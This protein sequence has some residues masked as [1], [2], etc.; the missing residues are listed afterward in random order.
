[1]ARYVE[2]GSLGFASGNSR[3]TI[4]VLFFIGLIFKISRIANF[5]WLMRQLTESGIGQ[6]ATS[7]TARVRVLGCISPVKAFPRV[8]R[9]VF[10]YCHAFVLP[11]LEHTQAPLDPFLGAVL[12]LPICP[13]LHP[14]ARPP[15]DMPAP[16]LSAPACAT[17]RPFCSQFNSLPNSNPRVRSGLWRV[18]WIGRPPFLVDDDCRLYAQSACLFWNYLHS[19]SGV[20]ATE[21][22][23]RRQTT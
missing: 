20:P 3:P 5:P 4:H 12:R 11:S 6:S 2:C 17:A 10:R 1:M 19:Q 16:R 7:G 23:W 13:W 18:S 21:I 9:P 8:E 15:P 14:D 22:S